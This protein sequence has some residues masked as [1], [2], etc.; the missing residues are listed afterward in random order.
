[1]T[2]TWDDTSTL[3]GVPDEGSEFFVRDFDRAEILDQLGKPNQNFLISQ[4]V[5]WTSQTIE[6]SGKRKIWIRKCGTNQVGSVGR[7]ITTFVIGVNGHVE[8]HQFDEFWIVISDHFAIIG[9]PIEG[10]INCWEVSNAIH[11]IFVNVFPVGGFVDT[12]IVS[13]GKLG[14]SVHK[15]DGSRELGHWVNIGWQ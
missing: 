1:M 6:G 10:W 7:D 5:K 13:L 15:G 8:S 14:L 3:E 4:T 11:A 9:G 2:V 12:F